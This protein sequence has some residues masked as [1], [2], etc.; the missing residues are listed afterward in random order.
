MQANWG[1]EKSGHFHEF[2]HLGRMYSIVSRFSVF[3]R[4]RVDGKFFPIIKKFLFEKSQNV[5]EKPLRNIRELLLT[6]PERGEWA[7][8]S[9]VKI[10]NIKGGVN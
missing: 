3:S 1:Y 8:S 2:Y 6:P 5:I 4:I 9:W 10:I 7:L